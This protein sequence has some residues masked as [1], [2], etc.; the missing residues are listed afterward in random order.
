[1]YYG[2][3]MRQI[4]G[5][6]VDLNFLPFAL[7]GDSKV[8]CMPS[9]VHSSRG[10]CPEVN[11]GYVKASIGIIVGIGGFWNGMCG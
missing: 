3:D 11:A 6:R 5:F 1:M 9:S 8:W 4:A 7:T 2:M 10:P